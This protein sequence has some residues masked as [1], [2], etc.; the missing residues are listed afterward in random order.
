MKTTTTQLLFLILIISGLHAAKIMHSASVKGVVVQ[1]EKIKN[2][3]AI[4]GSDTTQVNPLEDGY[5]NVSLKPGTWKIII[6]SKEGF[7]NTILN[8]IQ[9]IEG[10]NIDLG[11][12]NLQ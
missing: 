1:D 11:E 3:W 4:Q 12:I 7:K 10:K 8:N 6:Q 5:F 2:I 9:A